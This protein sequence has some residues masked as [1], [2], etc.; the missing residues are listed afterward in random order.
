[1][2]TPGYRDLEAAG[3]LDPTA[4]HITGLALGDPH[5][6]AWAAHAFVFADARTTHGAAALADAGPLFAINSALEIDLF[7]QVNLE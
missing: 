1:M 3:A 6:M 2:V 7:G 4:E 5:F